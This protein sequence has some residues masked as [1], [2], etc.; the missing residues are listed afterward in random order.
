MLLSSRFAELLKLLERRMVAHPELRAEMD[1]AKAGVSDVPV[2]P[3]RVPPH[4]SS[5]PRLPSV[6]SSVSIPEP[7]EVDLFAAH[8]LGPVRPW[9]KNTKSM[10]LTYQGVP[11]NFLKRGRLR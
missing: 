5:Q 6:S 8:T 4:A 10:P 9:G 7:L 1:E 2:S 11:G 3:V